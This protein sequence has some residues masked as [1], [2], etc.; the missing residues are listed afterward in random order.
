MCHSSASHAFPQPKVTGVVHGPI[1]ALR[2]G[3]G[4]GKTIA[5]LPDIYGPN[6][7]YQGFSEFL[8]EAGQSE[9]LL[10]H[11]FAKFGELSAGTREE[12]FRRRDLLDDLAFMDDLDEFLESHAVD[13][14][15]GFCIGGLFAFELAR[16]GYQGSLVAFYPFPQGLANR[17]PVPKPWTYLHEVQ[18][19][20]SILVGSKDHLLGEE[21]LWR[22]GETARANP[23]I[24][25]Q[26]Y[27]GMG[28]GFLQ[29]LDSDDQQLSAPA[30]SSLEV[31]RR[32]LFG[33]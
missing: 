33:D 11:P 32:H 4:V 28:H 25:L 1:H 19:P 8:A 24:R 23:N 20:V 29:N 18:T 6:P 2:F 3:N 22:L 7:F 26:V 14:V 15:V 9:V 21:N 30:M 10:V 5:V 12:A 16:R 13:G 27:E 17:N 31:C